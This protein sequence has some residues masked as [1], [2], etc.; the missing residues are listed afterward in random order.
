MENSNRRLEFA[1]SLRGIACLSVLVWHYIFTFAAIHGEYD[2][3]PALSTNAYPAAL[4]RLNAPDTIA[5]FGPFGVALFFLISGLVIPISVDAFS[6]RS[7]PRVAFFVSR[8]F[9]I[10][11]TYAVGAGI[12]LLALRWGA[13]YGGHSYDPV[14]ALYW[15]NVSL[16]R[17]WTPLPPFDGVVWT[18]EV[19]SKFYL[20]VLLAW[21]LLCRR[22]LAPMIVLAIAAIGASPYRAAYPVN[23]LG[24][25]NFIWY[26]KY[27]EFMSIG[28]VFNYHY[29]GAITARALKQ[30][31]GGLFSAFVIACAVERAPIDVPVSYG[32]A[33]MLF[34]W[35]YFRRIRWNGGKLC[36]FFAAI[37]FPLYAVH[38]PIGYVALRVLMGNGWS[39]L[40]AFAIVTPC[41]T[42][43]AWVMHIS[44]ERSSQ[45]LGKWLAAKIGH[46]GVGLFSARHDLES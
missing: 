11:P 36:R 37:S 31:A 7:L 43:L 5:K 45:T 33:L 40:G 22:S 28:I 14:G 20:F 18:L 6:T 32:L 38:A 46:S 13:A 19:E 39:G 3:F 29:R 42:S 1:N 35:M 12:S 44:V 41:V 4:L 30:T 16:F 25:G 17:D 21:M 10:V 24:L 15:S 27:V 2:G 8:A 9:R 34:G 23:S 26:L